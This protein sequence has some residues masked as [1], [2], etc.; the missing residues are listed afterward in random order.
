M[1]PSTSTSSSSAPASPGSPPAI[2]CRHSAPAR[3]Y[4]ILESRGSIGG[5]WDLFRYPGDPLGLRHVHA[6]LPLP[7]VAGRE[8]DRRRPGDPEL[9]A[10]DRERVRDRPE[11]PLQPPRR[12]RRV[13]ERGLAVDG[14]GAA[15]RHR[16]DGR[17][18]PAASCSCAAATTATTRATRPSSRAASGSEGSIVHPQHWDE[19]LDYTGKRVVVIGSGATAVTLVPAMAETG[20]ARDDASALAELHRLAS[21]RGPDRA[22]LRRILPARLAYAVAAVEERA[23][24]L[25]QLLA[26]PAAPEA[27]QGADPQGSRAKLPRRLR[28]RHAL[29]AELQPLG[30]ADVPGPRRRPLQGDLLRTRVGGDRSD[31]DASTRTGSSSSPGRSSRPT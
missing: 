2:T 28:R 26:Q 12:R 10:R 29:Q 20:G 15:H 27:G 4:A 19:E 6:R 11:D 14:R 3:R 13:V 22:L 21:R 5:T 1:T 24:D 8:D 9:R 18:S 23:D 17:S 7:A 31:Q 16:G 30:P 25:G